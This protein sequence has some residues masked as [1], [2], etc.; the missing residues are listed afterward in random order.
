MLN[1]LQSSGALVSRMV[2][3]FAEDGLGFGPLLLLKQVQTERGQG[4]GVLRRI[5]AGFA[6][7][8]I[9]QFTQERQ[10]PVEL[11]GGLVGVGEVVHAC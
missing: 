6:L 9:G 7:P 5:R 10:R 11:T 3:S 1:V 4:P 8:E 2:R